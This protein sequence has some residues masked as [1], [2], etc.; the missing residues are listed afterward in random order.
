MVVGPGIQRLNPRDLRRSGLVQRDV[1]LK[2][3]HQM[4]HYMAAKLFDVFKQGRQAITPDD[5]TC[6]AVGQLQRYRQT[7]LSGLDRP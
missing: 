3:R 5:L 6:G 1:N 7:G 4:G 2:R